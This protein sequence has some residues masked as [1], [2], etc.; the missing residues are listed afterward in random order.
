M[1]V[2]KKKERLFSVKNGPLQ[3]KIEIELK[4][5]IEKWKNKK[6]NSGLQKELFKNI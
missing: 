3:S 1:G 2:S 4:M 6:N 5:N